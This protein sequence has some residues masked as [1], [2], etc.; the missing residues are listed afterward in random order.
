MINND[1]TI[2][3]VVTT[4]DGKIE[5]VHEL[6]NDQWVKIIEQGSQYYYQIKHNLVYY[7]A[8]D[9]KKA[10]WSDFELECDFVEGE[11][12]FEIDTRLSEGEKPTPEEAREIY[13]KFKKNK[14]KCL[15]EVSGLALIYDKVVC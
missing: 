3:F 8:I 13:E 12:V 4:E 2:L 15:H 11:E 10:K 1:E 14:S 5:E 7:P 6:I 9:D